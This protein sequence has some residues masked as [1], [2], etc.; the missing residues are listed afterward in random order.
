[1]EFNVLFGEHTHVTDVEFVAFVKHRELL[2][3]VEFHY[4]GLVGL[5]SEL[6]PHGIQHHFGGLA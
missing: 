1:V 4:L 3:I 6:A 2:A 5:L